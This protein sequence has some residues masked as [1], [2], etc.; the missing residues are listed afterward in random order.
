MNT[1]E[2]YLSLAKE[3]VADKH[4]YTGWDEVLYRY[5]RVLL[6]PKELSSLTIES[7]ELALTNQA[8]DAEKEITKHKSLGVY[9]LDQKWV[10]EIKWQFKSPDTEGEWYECTHAQSEQFKLIET[11]GFEIRRIAII[12]PAQP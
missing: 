1:P 11:K 4:G 12:K 6:S 8:E 7:C 9:E 5:N 10:A 2:F 3:K